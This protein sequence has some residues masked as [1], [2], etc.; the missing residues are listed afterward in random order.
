MESVKKMIRTGS[1]WTCRHGNDVA[2]RI[3]N[4]HHYRGY[5]WVNPSS[6][7]SMRGISFDL[8]VLLQMV[9]EMQLP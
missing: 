5:S 7:E 9:E 3:D 8:L 6:E 2:S 4:R 1:Q